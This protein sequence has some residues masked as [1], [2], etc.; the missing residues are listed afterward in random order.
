VEASKMSASKSEPRSAFSNRDSFSSTSTEA[1]SSFSSNL[2]SSQRQQGRVSSSMEVGNLVV[3]EVRPPMDE[4]LADLPGDTTATVSRIEEQV[5]PNDPLWSEGSKSHQ[6]GQCRPCAWFFKEKGCSLGRDCNFCHQCPDG[7]VRTRRK[8]K[9]EELR[10]Q[11]QE[12]EERIAL[13]PGRV[14]FAAQSLHAGGHEPF[15]QAWPE[16]ESRASS[17]T[18]LSSASP[19]FVPSQ[20]QIVYL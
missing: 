3:D 10:R 1:R 14:S 20:S 18:P 17:L 6:S 2:S 9:D 12:K 16:P 19:S 7:Q 13:R 15:P 8:A 4:Q 11:R 5:G